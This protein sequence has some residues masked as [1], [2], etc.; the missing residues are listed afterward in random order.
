MKK[1]LIVAL[2]LGAAAA[3]AAFGFR[4]A[5]TESGLAVGDAVTPFHPMHLAG[6]NKGTD[7]CPPCTYGNRPQVQ[8]WVNEDEESNVLAI[9]TA[10]SKEVAASTTDL[11]AFVIKVAS[12][13]GCKDEAKAWAKAAEDKKMTNVGIAYLA[14]TDPAVKNYKHNTGKDV[15]NTVVIYKDKKVAAKFVNMQ[16]D[17]AGIAQLKSAIAAL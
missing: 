9:T 13:G 17:A 2:A 8:V 11:K 10:L 5:G 7:A 16:G 14:G 4:A 12:C 15:K 6:P 1:S 3:M